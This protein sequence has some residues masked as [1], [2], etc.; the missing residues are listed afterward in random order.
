M[1]TLMVTDPQMCTECEACINACK[2]NL[3]NC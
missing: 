3:W 1:K 2:K